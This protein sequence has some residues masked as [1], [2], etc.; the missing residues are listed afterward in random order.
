V[1]RKT[2]P[3]KQLARDLL[4]TLSD[5]R[6][7]RLIRI[8]EEIL[9]IWHDVSEEHYPTSKPRLKITHRAYSSQIT[10]LGLRREAA[11][12]L[13]A[14]RE[15]SPARYHVS[16]GDGVSFRCGVRISAAAKRIA[17]ESLLKQAEALAGPQAR[18]AD[19][20]ASDRPH[21]HHG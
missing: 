21:A 2:T 17:Y 12:A 15:A 14:I 8:E 20:D 5:E 3:P 7:L 11:L 13:C 6:M 18:T 16:M 19:M 10:A 9:E 1:K 4:S